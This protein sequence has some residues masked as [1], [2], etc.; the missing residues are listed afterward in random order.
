MRAQSETFLGSQLSLNLTKALATLF[1]SKHL[2]QNVEIESDFFEKH[3]RE[4]GRIA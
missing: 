1:S 2:Y 4:A 3:I